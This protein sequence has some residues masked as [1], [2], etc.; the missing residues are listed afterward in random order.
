MRK[1][2]QTLSS[3]W[4]NIYKHW[5]QDKE[6]IYKQRAHGEEYL[7]TGPTV[8]K[9]LQTYVELY[10]VIW[11]YLQWSVVYRWSSPFSPFSP[12]SPFSLLQTDNFRLFL[13]QQTDKRQTTVWMMSNGKQMKENH[14]GFVLRFSFACKPSKYPN[15]LIRSW[16]C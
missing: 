5:A 16:I 13:H 10:N 12:S 1:C 6:N 11:E 9:H 3:W 4:R 15:I 14:L 2:L 7:L 8:R